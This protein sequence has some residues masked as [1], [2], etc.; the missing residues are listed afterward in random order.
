[1]RALAP[2]ACLEKKIIGVLSG[3]VVGWLVVG[4]LVVGWLVVGWLVVEV[5][6]D[7]LEAAGLPKHTA[8]VVVGGVVGA[9]PRA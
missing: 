1:M 9:W 7:A 5:A 6:T 8:E 2:G 4:W 3:L